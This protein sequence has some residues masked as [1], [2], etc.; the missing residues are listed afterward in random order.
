MALSFFKECDGLLLLEKMEAKGAGT[1]DWENQEAGAMFF[2]FFF[3]CS[4][5]PSLRFCH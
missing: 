2:F 3:V 4:L 5:H 1:C